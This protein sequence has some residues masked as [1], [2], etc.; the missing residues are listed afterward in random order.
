MKFFYIPDF[1]K[2]QNVDDSA[3]SIAEK[4]FN[5][6]IFSKKQNDD[7]SEDTGSITKQNNIDIDKANNI[8]IKSYDKDVIEFCIDCGADINYKDEDNVTVLYNACKRSDVELVRYLLQQPGINVNGYGDKIPL[9]KTMNQQIIEMLIKAGADINIKDS[10]NVTLL[11]QLCTY[12][13]NG[14]IEYLLQQPGI[15]VNG[16]GEFHPILSLYLDLNIVKKLV[17]AGANINV[18]NSRDETP[19]ISAIKLK[20]Y[21]VVKFLASKGADLT[22]KDNKGKTVYD[23]ITEFNIDPSILQSN[24]GFVSDKFSSLLTQEEKDKIIFNEISKR[25]NSEKSIFIKKLLETIK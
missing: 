19:I 16:S 18:Q 15:N 6:P 22:I 14:Q 11:Y 12:G 17:E 23:Y 13:G 2:K 3:E 10:N 24:Y 1:S 25:D 21:D 4:Y 9:L 8:I 7:D 5:I 20:R